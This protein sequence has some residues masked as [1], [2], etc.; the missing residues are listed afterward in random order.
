VPSLE[1]LQNE[2]SAWNSGRSSWPN[3]PTACRTIRTGWAEDRLRRDTYERVQPRL[4]SPASVRRN[5]LRRQYAA[6]IWSTRNASCPQ[7]G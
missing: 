3:L 4:F 1:E 6:A 2:L 5:R 7:S